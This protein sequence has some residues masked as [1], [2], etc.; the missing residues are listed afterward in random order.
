MSSDKSKACMAQPATKEPIKDG[1][2]ILVDVTISNRDNEEVVNTE[3]QVGVQNIEGV[4]AA[5]TT[6]ALVI[7]YILMWLIYFVE[8]VFSGMQ[9]ALNPFVTS[10]FAMHS[11]TPTVS[12]VSS[13]IGGCTNF[14]VAKM[15][16]VLGRPTGYLICIVIATMGFIM[17]AACRT[18][19]A[20]AA[21]LIFYTVGNTGLQYTLSVFIA[22]T[23]SLRNR[24]LMQAFATSANLITCWL[25]G[26]IS[27]GFLNGPGWP[28][29]FG[30][31]SIL[32]PAFS[33]PLYGLLQ[34]YDL[35]A[36]RLNIVPG[37]NSHGAVWHSILYYCREFD[38]VGLVLLSAGAALFLLPFNLYLLQPKGWDS[39]LIIC[40]LV[41]GV[42]LLLLFVAW[43][44]FF[45]PVTFI[46]YSLLLDR[47]LLGACILSATLFFS[48]SCWAS[49]LSSFLQVVN[50]LSLTDAS[51]VM[52]IQTVGSVLFS[53]V[54]GAV[55]RYTGHFKPV[56]LY[57]AIP[58]IILGT[59]LMIYFHQP[60]SVGFIVMCQIFM[61]F[62]SGILIV[63]DEIAALA[64]A[65]H[66]H[67]AVV[68][69]TISFSGSIGGAIGLTVAG[70]IW[71]VV[72]PKKL[73]E[74]LPASELPA[75][76]TI[77][78]D[79]ETQLSYAVGSPARV[80]IERAYGS[81][82]GSLLIAATSI[83]ALGFLGVLMW[84]N[85]NV[86]EVKQVKGQVV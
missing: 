66:Q 45:A 56:C 73:A 30:A 27:T 1:R 29:A 10:A 78:T 13:V 20:Y 61:A 7:A 75:L 16:D 65:E 48:Y 42:V 84:R 35:K 81:A 43:E 6:T 28:W 72:L 58:L 60:H 11:L 41:F 46:P 38:A 62:A 37:R 50:N 22:D 68:I 71:Q 59:G 8:G 77:Y 33:L 2:E 17:M 23:S 18:V 24:G 83:W 19:E 21:A 82:Q 51:Y 12:I 64:A 26:P 63:C 55:I 14:T 76:I 86:K 85:I 40:L 39:P 36:Q 44:R 54:A 4:T 79:L 74:F 53:F 67:V 31:F 52:Q 49:F 47:T 25:A 70:A 3:A 5:W 69:A 32:V 9:A 15:L 34:Y 80:A 57:F